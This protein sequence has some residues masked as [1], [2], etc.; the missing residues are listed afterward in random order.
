MGGRRGHLTQPSPAG[1][2][3]LLDW[4]LAARTSHLTNE[5]RRGEASPATA[6]VESCLSPHVADQLFPRGTSRRRQPALT[7]WTFVSGGKGEKS[8]LGLVGFRGAP[9]N[10]SFPSQ[11]EQQDRTGQDR[12]AG[13]GRGLGARPATSAS[14][15]LRPSPGGQSDRL[16]VDPGASLVS[17]LPSSLLASLCLSR[18]RRR[19]AHLTSRNRQ[20]D[21]C[22]SG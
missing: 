13:G 2:R 8:W 20:T 5:A 12:T 9:A 15:P 6:A 7:L 3:G 11:K 22:P 14:S 16:A 19:M 17:R 18:F 4:P 21:A 1:A 10:G